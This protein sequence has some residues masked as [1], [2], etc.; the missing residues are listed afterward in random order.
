MFRRR[1]TGGLGPQSQGVFGAEEGF[2][3]YVR[4]RI[5]GRDGVCRDPSPAYA[6]D[7]GEFP[8]QGPDQIDARFEGHGGTREIIRGHQGILEYRPEPV[9]TVRH[10]QSEPEAQVISPVTP[11][12]TESEIKVLVRP[13]EIAGWHPDSGKYG[14]G[15]ASAGMGVL[16]SRPR[17][18]V[19]I[20][21]SR[22]SPEDFHEGV[23]PI[24]VDGFDER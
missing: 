12:G 20:G 2:C 9:R 10:Y 4:G 7:Q 17:L 13:L 8:I 5:P 1:S 3:P 24:R 11:S 14:A 15:Y 22:F 16:K 23:G 19:Q 6:S 21:F 18:A